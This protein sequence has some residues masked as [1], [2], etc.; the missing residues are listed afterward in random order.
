MKCPTC[1]GSGQIGPSQDNTPYAEMRRLWNEERGTLPKCCTLSDHRKL[2]C[3]RV[4]KI[5]QDMT[6]LRGAFRAAAHDP[7]YR[8]ARWG[9]DT[10][11]RHAER[12][13]EAKVPGAAQDV[14]YGP[15]RPAV[16]QLPMVDDRF[17]KV[18][19]R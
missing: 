15:D 17:A 4:Y 16:T 10:V 8:E 13:M 1:N 6:A 11:L 14:R 2:L 18:L 12:W 7:K 5:T 9:F 3:R 19:K